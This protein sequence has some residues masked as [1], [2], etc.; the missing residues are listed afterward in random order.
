[1]TSRAQF[2]HLSI[3]W[4]S[5]DSVVNPVAALLAPFSSV[6]A[7]DRRATIEV[8]ARTVFDAVRETWPELVG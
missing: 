3:A 2:H 6:P 7:P 1:M 5:A 8:L 4:S